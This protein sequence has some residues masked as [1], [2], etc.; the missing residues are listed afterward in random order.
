MDESIGN[1]EKIIRKSETKASE[2]HKQL[3]N[4]IKSVHSQLRNDCEKHGAS[5]AWNMHTLQEEKLHVI[6]NTFFK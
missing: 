6:I 4:F 2:K 5:E 3:A 1:K